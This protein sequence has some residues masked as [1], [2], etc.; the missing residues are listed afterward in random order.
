MKINKFGKTLTSRADG[1]EASMAIE[2]PTQNPIIFDFEGVNTLSPGWLDEFMKKFKG[3]RTVEFKNID[4]L[5]VRKTL[6]FLKLNNPQHK[7]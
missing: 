2:L 6:E 3:E 5:S 1:K 4:N 7:E